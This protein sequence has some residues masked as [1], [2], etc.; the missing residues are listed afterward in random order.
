MLLIPWQ[1][2][3]RV[4]LE[5]GSAP[6][7]LTG[8]CS[9]CSVCCAGAEISSTW[10]EVPPTWPQ[11]SHLPAEPRDPGRVCSLQSSQLCGSTSELLVCRVEE[12]VTGTGS[13]PPR[14]HGTL[15]LH[16]SESSLVHENSLQRDKVP[17]SWFAH[18]Y[19]VRRKKW[20]RG[21][22]LCLTS[23]GLRSSCPGMERPELFTR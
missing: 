12:G 21:T 5:S 18:S 2:P 22:L 6:L 23:P 19:A 11:P 8:I 9:V 4:R 17:H 3:P 20:P 16:A 15:R 14:S 13:I 1:S 10:V 7:L